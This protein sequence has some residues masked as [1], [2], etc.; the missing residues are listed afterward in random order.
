MGDRNATERV[1]KGDT[2]VLELQKLVIA[3][4][5][6]AKACTTATAGPIPIASLISIGPCCRSSYKGL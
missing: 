5:G 4:E 6:L 3:L 1:V 2:L